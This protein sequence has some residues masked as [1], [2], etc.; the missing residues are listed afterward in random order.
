VV[1]PRPLIRP[2]GCRGRQRRILARS[3]RHLDEQ[4]LPRPAARHLVD[5]EAAAA[6]RRAEVDL[7]PLSR[8]RLGRDVA[9]TGV[10]LARLWADGKDGQS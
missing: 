5:L 2:P 7:D 8:A 10:D 3:L 6:K 1:R 4:G 9:A